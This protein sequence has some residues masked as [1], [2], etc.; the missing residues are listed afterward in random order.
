MESLSDRERF[1]QCLLG[2]EVD[3]PPFW[4]TQPP[5]TVLESW[6]VEGHEV[7]EWD[8]FCAAFGCD[9]PPQAVPVECGPCPKL[10]RLLGEDEH[11]AVG[12]D[13]W[14]QKHVFVRWL[15]YHGFDPPV[16]SVEDWQRYK[17]DYLQA[18]TPRRFEETWWPAM[19][20][21]M[22]KGSP[23]CLGDGYDL[24]LVTAAAYLLGPPTLLAAARQMASIVDDI[25]NHLSQHYLAILQQVLEAGVQVDMIRLSDRGD[26]GLDVDQYRRLYEKPLGRIIRFARQHDIPLIAMEEP[27]LDEK[28]LPMLTELG[29]NCL[30]D[31][32]KL[33][34][35]FLRE[36]YPRLGVTGGISLADVKAGRPA[37]DARLKRI[38]QWAM[39]GRFIPD[40]EAVPFI[41]W[42]DFAYLAGGLKEALGVQA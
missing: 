41:A 33:E 19:Q 22:D 31:V 1:V 27:P 7:G 16:K 12:M 29:I 37:I 32:Q 15:G 24:H 38:G 18:E 20:A 4:L 11:H 10:G 39:G 8:D 23:I 40:I 21:C 25:L 36:T 35:D 34:I 5:D 26:F 17:E 42:D 3:R 14:G 28:L 2:Q 6:R 9:V 30:V 13:S